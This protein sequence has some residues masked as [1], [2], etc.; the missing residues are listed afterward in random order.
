M[1]STLPFSKIVGTGNDFVFID[2]RVALPASF[3]ALDR[4]ELVRRLCDRHFGVG[5][6]GA[7]FVETTNQADHLRWDF[8]NSD[9]S[10]AEMCGNA[11]RCMGRWAER[12]LCARE[13]RFE[14]LAGLVHA[15][16]D[17]AM[18]ASE[19]PFVHARMTEI[20]FEAAGRKRIAH[21]VNTGV[22]HVVYAIEDI[23]QAASCQEEIR[24]LRFHPAAG[25]R[26]ANVTFL[27]VHGPQKFS[28]VTFE[29]GVEDFTLS[30]GTGV[31]A[32]A[33]V[34]LSA[35]GKSSAKLETPGGSLEVQFGANLHGV[36]LKGPADLVFVGQF[37]QRFL[38]EFLKELL[39]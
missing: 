37:S 17:G 7:V 9:G 23:Q 8:Y 22:P 10:I 13:V 16:C 2:A 31:I 4:A 28:T 32:A 34:G 18:V 21:L 27:A 24:A 35:S 15:K 29:R 25:P 5:A 39:K 1:E 14:T 20:E 6:D 38:K 30:C 12:H 19:L 11:T 33:A 3:A 36:V 26:G